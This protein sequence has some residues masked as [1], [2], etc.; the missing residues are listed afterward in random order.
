MD[1][2]AL[3]YTHPY[4]NNA[5]SESASSGRNIRSAGINTTPGVG[6]ICGFYYPGTPRSPSLGTPILPA[7]L[8]APAGIFDIAIYDGA[9]DRLNVFHEKLGRGA[10]N[11]HCVRPYPVFRKGNGHS[12]VRL[13]VCF[14]CVTTFL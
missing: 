10:R 3:R 8:I 11:A 1:I 12:A 7:H 9:L 5:L 6:S 4:H 14:L 2:A 13:D